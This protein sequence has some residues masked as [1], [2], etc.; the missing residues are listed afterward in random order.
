MKID[1]YI[2]KIIQGDCLEIIKEM[3]NNSIDLLVTSPPYNIDLGNNKYNKKSYDIYVDN[4]DHKSYI[5]WLKNIF[6]E[7]YKILKVGGR[8]AINIGDAKNGK[9]PTS[10]DVIQFMV[11]LN[12]IPMTHII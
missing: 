5:S 2:N 1:K 9:I 11:D 10:S 6:L 7:V 4:K 8:V 3:P 12:Y